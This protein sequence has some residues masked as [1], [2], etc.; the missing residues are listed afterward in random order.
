MFLA[1]FEICRTISIRRQ[2]FA[3]ASGELDSLHTDLVSRGIFSFPKQT[4]CFEGVLPRPAY[5]PFVL[6]LREQGGLGGDCSKVAGNDLPQTAGLLPDKTSVW[7]WEDVI[8]I[9]GI[10]DGR[11]KKAER[12]RD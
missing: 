9:F 7:L 12:A 5:D 3:L 2:R 4:P 10:G 11:E 6:S 1:M 8:F